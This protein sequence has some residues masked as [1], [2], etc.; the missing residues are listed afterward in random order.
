MR[1]DFKRIIIHRIVYGDQSGKAEEP[2]KTSPTNRW[3]FYLTLI[4]TAIVVIVL[5][6]FFFSI[7]LALFAAVAAAVGA[8]IWWLRRKLRQAMR[9][10]AKEQDKRDG[11][12]DAEIIEVKEDTADPHQRH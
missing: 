9:S 11:I 12:I 8:R 7:V 3:L 5:G 2:L 10:A 4:P 1:D 6:A